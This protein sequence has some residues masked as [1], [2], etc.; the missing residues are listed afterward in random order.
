MLLSRCYQGLPHRT[1]WGLRGEAVTTLGEATVL[2]AILCLAALPTGVHVDEGSRLACGALPLWQSHARL[3]LFAHRLLFV[4]AHVA[5]HHVLSSQHQLANIIAATCG[6][7]R[8]V[9]LQEA[10]D[11]VPHTSP[12]SSSRTLATRTSP[13]CSTRNTFEPDPAV[14]AFNEASTS[15]DTWSMVLLIVR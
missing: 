4:L 3:S 14:F 10:S 5:R 9:I 13:S 12:S 6:Q 2:V 11:H 15:K 8:A 1:S 7:F